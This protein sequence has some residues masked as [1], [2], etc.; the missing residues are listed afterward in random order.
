M[1]TQQTTENKSKFSISKNFTNLTPNQYWLLEHQITAFWHGFGIANG[2]DVPIEETEVYELPE[3][4]GGPIKQYV[5][6]KA[7]YMQSLL[8][9]YLAWLTNYQGS[10]NNKEVYDCYPKDFPAFLESEKNS[11]GKTRLPILA[12]INLLQNNKPTEG[13]T[14]NRDCETHFTDTM[15]EHGFHGEIYSDGQTKKF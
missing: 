13:L 4:K 5:K 1:I 12:M 10:W 2:L 11:N 15:A 14:D 7:S 3:Y 6:V 8:A 9:E